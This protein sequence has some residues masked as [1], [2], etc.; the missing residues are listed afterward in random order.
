MSFKWDFAYRYSLILALAVVSNA[1]AQDVDWRLH[2]LD[3]AGSRFAE[4]DQ[5]TPENA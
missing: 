1:A 3:L 5:I 4:T 2:N